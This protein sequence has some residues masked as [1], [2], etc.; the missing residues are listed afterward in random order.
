[1]RKVGGGFGKRRSPRPPPP[2]WG[3]RR[4]DRGTVLFCFFPRGATSAVGGNFCAALLWEFIRVGDP[5]P[6][7]RVSPLF[8][9]APVVVCPGV[10]CHIS[11][12][13][14]LKPVEI[15]GVVSAWG[16]V[17]FCERRYNRSA[18]GLRPPCAVGLQ[19]SKGQVKVIAQRGEDQLTCGCC[20][21]P[22][23]PLVSHDCGWV[24]LGLWF[25]PRLSS[26]WVVW[27]CP[28]GLGHKQSQIE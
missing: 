3:D 22:R 2:P 16:G 14:F 19:R 10:R 1:V 26:S 4:P 21:S 24:W 12:C 17:F 8:L 20:L 6:K 13:G 25:G 9:I 7:G 5:A 11:V 23:F 27:C 18:A 28:T 15:N